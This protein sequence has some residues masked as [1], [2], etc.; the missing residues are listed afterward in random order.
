MLSRSIAE[1]AWALP[2]ESSIEQNLAKVKSRRGIYE[3]ALSEFLNPGVRD[4]PLYRFAAR[5]HR[6]PGCFDSF[7]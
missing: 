2:G 5:M 1:G 6:K 4:S 7:S 3:G